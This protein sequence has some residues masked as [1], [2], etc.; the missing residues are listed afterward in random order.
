MLY[1]KQIYGNAS[2]Y[3]LLLQLRCITLFLRSVSG[4]II[5]SEKYVTSCQN[6]IVL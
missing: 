6:V 1:P 3:T 2:I 5:L 4:D